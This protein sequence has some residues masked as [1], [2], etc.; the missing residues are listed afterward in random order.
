MNLS[1]SLHTLRRRWVLTLVLLALVGAGAAG[2]AIKLPR[3]YES[4]SQIAFLSSKTDSRLYYNSNPYLAFDDSLNVAADVVGRRMM[5]PRVV[6]ALAADGYTGS[7]VVEDAPTSPGPVL[8]ITVT[9]KNPTEAESTLQGV[10]DAVA[11][12]LSSMQSEVSQQ[13]RI[14]D[15]VLSISVKATLSLSKMA[16]PLAAVI[17]VGLVLVISI[18]L[19][20]EGISVR[21]RTKR[22]SPQTPDPGP[23]DGTDVPSATAPS[24]AHPSFDEIGSNGSK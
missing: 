23:G 9:A 19:I 16:R 13:D 8:I 24:S 14:T 20:V 4:T 5:D 7:Y 1:E 12:Q 3:T 2:A 15:T 11:T 21:R 6:S 18:P 17:V 22:G 10:T